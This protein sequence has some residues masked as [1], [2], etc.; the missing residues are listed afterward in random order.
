MDGLKFVIPNS[1]KPVPKMQL[2]LFDDNDQEEQCPGCAKNDPHA[3]TGT[4]CK[5][6]DWELG[7][8][9]TFKDILEEAKK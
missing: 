3:H 2:S 8:T 7:K 4:Y 1:C 6:K 5:I 9:I